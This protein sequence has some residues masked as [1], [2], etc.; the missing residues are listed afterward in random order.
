MCGKKIVAEIACT[1]RSA[2]KY[3]FYI[4]KTAELLIT[5]VIQHHFFITELVLH[6]VIPSEKK[7][8]KERSGITM[9]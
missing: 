3:T 1:R 8:C 5:L 4:K 6:Y 9:R 2:F 7:V